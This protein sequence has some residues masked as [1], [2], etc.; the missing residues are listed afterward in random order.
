MV[1]DTN[2]KWSKKRVGPW[3]KLPI[4][5]RR[6]FW[7][8]HNLVQYG[9]A[10]EGRGA[11]AFGKS[12]TLSFPNIPRLQRVH[13]F[14]I[15]FFLLFSPVVLPFLFRLTLP[16]INF[17]STSL[18]NFILQFCAGRSRERKDKDKGGKQH[19]QQHGQLQEVQVW[20][21][22]V[23]QLVIWFTTYFNNLPNIGFAFW[24]W[25]KQ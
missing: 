2:L 8:I 3:L 10:T 16:R 18:S 25:S 20:V 6:H 14:D 12:L 19:Q 24:S 11:Y 4:S 1:R 9:A 5:R 22:S 7:E 17:F 21:C 15:F 23:A 13:N